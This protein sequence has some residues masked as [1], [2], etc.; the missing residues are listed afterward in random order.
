MTAVWLGVRNSPEDT[1]KRKMMAAKD[2]GGKGP[3]VEVHGQL[4]EE[5]VGGTGPE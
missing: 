5:E 1:A 4:V 3:V 2:D